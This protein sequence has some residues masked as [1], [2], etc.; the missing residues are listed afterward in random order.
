MPF[1]KLRRVVSVNFRR[2]NITNLITNRP[3]FYTYTVSECPLRENVF[4]ENPVRTVPIWD[5][6]TRRQTKLFCWVDILQKKTKHAQVGT[7][8]LER[9]LT[10][11]RPPRENLR[12]FYRAMLS[13]RGTSHGPVSV[14]P[15]QVG[16]LLKRLN[17]SSWFWHVSFLL[18]VLHCIKR[19][20]GYLQK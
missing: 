9:Q 16:V 3:M 17:E 19:K 8:R 5:V 4:P 1:F 10:T 13:I 7:Y 14:C 20:F 11:K 15:S 12:D 18:P 2:R 6:L